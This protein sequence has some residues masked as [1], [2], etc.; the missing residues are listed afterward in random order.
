[1]T[2]HRLKLLLNDNSTRLY[3]TPGFGPLDHPMNIVMQI[4]RTQRLFH[5]H[6]SRMQLE[7]TWIGNLT[8]HDL[9][10]EKP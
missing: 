5:A 9:E 6:A 7:K 8:A 10:D 2:V 4:L 3:T 1:M